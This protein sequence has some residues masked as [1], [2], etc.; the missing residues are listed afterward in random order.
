MSW[1]LFFVSSTLILSFGFLF[2]LFFTQVVE[3]GKEKAIQDFKKAFFEREKWLFLMLGIV[4][5]IAILASAFFSLTL[6]QTGRVIFLFLEVLFIAEIVNIIYFDSRKYYLLTIEK[7]K[8]GIM[9][10]DKK[11]PQYNC[12]SFVAKLLELAERALAP[13]P[14]GSKFEVYYTCLKYVPFCLRAKKL[15][16]FVKTPEGKIVKFVPAEDDQERL[17]SE[18]NKC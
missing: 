9:I 6:N 16:F 7:T 5:F 17:T 3:E 4:A 10:A 11:L 8:E 15:H 2:I 12:N 18:L 13:Y 1:E 14:F